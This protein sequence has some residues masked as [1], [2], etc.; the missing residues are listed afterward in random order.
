MRYVTRLISRLALLLIVAAQAAGA[1]QLSTSY[2]LSPGD[3][4]EIS[5]LNHN[6]LDRTLT[7]LSDGSIA[8]PAV[9]EMTA[10][11]KTPKTLAE[12]L[13]KV[14]DK[15]LNNFAVTV[16]VKQP[17]PRKVRVVG[18]V[19]TPGMYD[20][21]DGA[22][23]LDLVAAAGGI[24]TKPELISARILRGSK[25]IPVDAFGAY[26]KPETA[27]N[28]SLEVDDLVLVD[29]MDPPATPH[30]Y[31]NGHVKKPAI[32]PLDQS[33]TILMMLGLA[34]GWTERAAVSKAYIIRGG[35]HLPLDLTPVKSG[36]AA[37]EIT[38]FKLENGDIL[39][40]PEIT[41]Q[42]A[43]FGA[44]GNPGYKPLPETGKMT[45]LDALNLSAIQPQAD[46]AKA[47]L[48]RKKSAGWESMPINIDK[49]LK[50]AELASNVDLQPEDII[51][52]PVKG[53][54]APN[55]LSLL[56]PLSLIGLRFIR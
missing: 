32:V 28:L 40:L 15:T 9:G 42:Y 16:T 10:A 4:I 41:T 7:V 49:L 53:E 17:R 8:L 43:I 35:R 14:L 1:Q 55:L 25:M 6:D 39:Y 27:A 31:V 52:I 29:Q 2:V 38:D 11:G 50:K 51:Y 18:A 34:E 3:V 36:R 33:T 45:L 24:T 47:T 46:L 23:V 21:L 54:R 20:F 22:R 56:N 5:I 26:Q 48:A 19:K 12:E 30:V 37:P 13:R 44:V